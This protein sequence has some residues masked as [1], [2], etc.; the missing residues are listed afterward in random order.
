MVLLVAVLAVIVLTAL[1][2]RLL[3][4]GRVRRVPPWDCGYALLDARMQDSAEG[5]GQ[6]IRHIFASFFSIERELP[7]PTDARPRYRV[8]VADR[9]WRALYEPLGSLVQRIADLC[10]R[11]QQ[12]SI[13]TY[14]LYSFITLVLLLALVL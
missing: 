4:H 5:F 11:L 1:A 12:G 3:Y 9:I 8:A 7:A 14:L 10:A 2:V 6:P 13:A